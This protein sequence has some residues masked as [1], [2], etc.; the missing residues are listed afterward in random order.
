MVQ[1]KELRLAEDLYLV[2]YKPS[3]V[4]DLLNN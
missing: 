3:E 1:M 4:Q 2:I